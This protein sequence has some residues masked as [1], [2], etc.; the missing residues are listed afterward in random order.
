MLPS[1][2]LAL[3]VDRGIVAELGENS[4]QALGHAAGDGVFAGSR[5]WKAGNGSEPLK[6]ALRRVLRRDAGA[7]K[8]EVLGQKWEDAV[9]ASVAQGGVRG[10]AQT[11]NLDV[12]VHG[13]A[14]P[15]V[16]GGAADGAL[17]GVEQVLAVGLA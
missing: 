1:R 5:G 10:V 13:G 15:Q 17:V 11:R 3:G 2:A 7:A 14:K 16:H 4:L 12:V 8:L 6:E 9:H